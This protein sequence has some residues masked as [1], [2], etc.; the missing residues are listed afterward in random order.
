MKI[1]SGHDDNTRRQCCTYL[2]DITGI[3]KRPLAPKC[4]YQKGTGGT[5]AFL[6]HGADISL[7]RPSRF[8]KAD[9]TKRS[10]NKL[11]DLPRRLLA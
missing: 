7:Q 9:Q 5:D 2:P 1:L 8:Q 11:R 3:P 10:K 6:F 4:M